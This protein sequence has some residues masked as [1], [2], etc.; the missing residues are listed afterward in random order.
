MNPSGAAFQGGSGAVMGAGARG[1][2]QRGGPGAHAD[3]PPAAGRAG[4]LIYALAEALG[5]PGA[6]A[7][8]SLSEER[9]RRAVCGTPPP[10]LAGLLPLLG[11]GSWWR[12][13]ASL[14]PVPFM[15]GKGVCA[16][17]FPAVAQPQVLWH[18]CPSLHPS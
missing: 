15:T 6:G 3:I 17:V 11:L 2:S 8:E 18:P 1:L 4:G 12:Q 16:S 10:L 14:G 13:R 9:K 5:L 7:A